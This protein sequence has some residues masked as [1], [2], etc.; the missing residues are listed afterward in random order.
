M[1]G[2]YPWTMARFYHIA[3]MHNRMYIRYLY[4]VHYKS[5]QA[6]YVAFRTKILN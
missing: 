2:Q 5:K 1:I 4:K 6:M 3:T